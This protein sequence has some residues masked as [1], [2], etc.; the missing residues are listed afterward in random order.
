MPYALLNSAADDGTVVYVCNSRVEFYY[1]S[2]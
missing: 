1:W 2:L